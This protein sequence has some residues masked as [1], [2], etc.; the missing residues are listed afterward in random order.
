MPRRTR[1]WL[2]GGRIAAAMVL[3]GVGV[4]LWSVGLTQ[5]SAIGG[6]VG[7]LVAV[8][9]LLAPY[10]LPAPS[11]PAGRARVVKSSGNA[12]ASSGG[13]ANTGVQGTGSNGDSRI[14]RSGNATSDGANS[15]ANTGIQDFEH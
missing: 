3:L 15:V 6:A 2:W 7:L 5:A 9:T 11:A 1:R 13:V 12:S 8:A 10:V 4:W 14:G